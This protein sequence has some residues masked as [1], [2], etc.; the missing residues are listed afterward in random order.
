MKFEEV[1]ERLN[2]SDVS[3]ERL[4]DECRAPDFALW[5]AHPELYVKFVDRLIQ[6]GHPGRALD[7]AKEG[8]KHLRNNSRLQYQLALAAARGGNSRYAEEL[9][10][11]LLAKAIGTDPRPTDLDTALAVEVIALKGRILKDRSA[12]EPGL[13]RESAK[14]Y[15]KAAAVPG[16]E[17]LPDAGTFPL[18]NAATMWRLAG[19]KAK[20]EQ[21]ATEV[22]RRIES[23]AGAA[24]A[25]GNLWPA[26][27]LGEALLLVGRHEEAMDW[28][29]RAVQVATARHE[30]GNLTSMRNN[31][32]RLQECGA[33]ADPQFIDE[34]LGTVVVFSGHMIDSPDRLE[35]GK[36]PRFPNHPALIDAVAKAIRDQLEALN[37]RVGYCSLACGG[38]ILFAEAML[39]R[40]AEL[41][42]VLPFAQHDFLRTSV[43]FGQDA[44]P[45]RKW[46]QRFDHVVDRLE[47][48]SGICLRYATS[49]PYLGC[50]ELFKFT[51]KM[52]QG[53]AVLR[54]RERG[55]KPAAIALI[56]QA[57]G[58]ADFLASW[59]AAG[60][61]DASYLIDI[62]PLRLAHPAPQAPVEPAAAPIPVEELTRP[63][64]AMLFADVAGFSKIKEWQQFKY[65]T[66]YANYLRE[67][68]A[69]PFGKTAI[70]ANTW[71]DALH[72]VFDSVAD[73]ASFACELLEPT[74]T[75]PPD[76]QAF[77]L[78]KITPFRVG[79]H[80]G[81]V[82]ELIDL[83]Q[84]RSEFAGQNVNRAARIE[85][86]TLRGCAYA[87]E[88]F[89]AL[90]MMQAGKDFLIEGVGEHSLAKDYDRCPLYRIQR[91]S[92]FVGSVY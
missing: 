27:T 8:E 24:A 91:A 20:S 44:S 82:F 41:H 15:E 38:D 36:P 21:L 83:F 64:K 49:E 1:L 34:H 31:L 77:G 65:R 71:G 73:A 90:L 10:E 74:V 80:T 50:D 37:A 45:W 23:Q 66:S 5:E 84:H 7:L 87:S 57:A 70:Y 81:P 22:I 40:Q 59:S 33:A 78:G 14:W 61:A 58:T 26:A 39:D 51:N 30:V 18:I 67:L 11:P 75:R 32:R 12:R 92:P 35:A 68:F 63:V 9:I 53:L 25:A 88:P 85:P 43:D 13:L 6:F 48:A 54:S 69:S 28:Y 19:E 62:A 47:N 89:A 86:A 16:A 60:Y 46:R 3:I 56:D 2:R 29:R 4:L 17:S 55:S 52:L 72:V 42:V 76:W 79:L